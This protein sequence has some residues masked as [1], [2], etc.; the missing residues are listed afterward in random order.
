[1]LKKAFLALRKRFFEFMVSMEFKLQ[2]GV[3]IMD[4]V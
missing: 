4:E 2:N 3:E 1:M